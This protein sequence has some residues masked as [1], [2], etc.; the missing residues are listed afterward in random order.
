MLE[1]ERIPLRAE[2]EKLL[3]VILL[4]DCARWAFASTRKL[5]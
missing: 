4:I 2:A 1:I 3:E 5:C